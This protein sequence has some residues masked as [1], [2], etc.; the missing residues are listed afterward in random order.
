MSSGS[1]SKGFWFFII[2]IFL[3]FFGF[4]FFLMSQMNSESTLSAVQQ[5]KPHK[6]DQLIGVVDIQGP[7]FESR[8]TIEKLHQASQ[9]NSLS[10]IIVRIDSPGGAVGPVQE[11]YEEILRI[12]KQKPVYASFGTIAASGGYYI[13]AAT[14]KIFANSGTLTG[15]IGVIFQFANLSKLYEW[16]KISLKTVKAGRYKDIGNPSREMTVEE[17]QLLQ[18]TTDQVHG[19]F[20]RD[21]LARRKDKIKGD[22][23]EYAQGQIFSGE[24]A[25]KIGLVDDIAGLWEAGRRI[26]QELKLKGEMELLFIK[27]K[28]PF[29][30]MDFLQTL[31]EASSSLKGFLKLQ[32]TPSFLY[33]PAH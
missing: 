32:N 5:Q 17:L 27:D 14:R 6:K 2:F 4:L 18:S 30:M 20:K 15:S 22:M 23:N 21:I 10:A 31:E 29:K 13:G 7:I 16:A 1:S 9:E 3:L 8:K 11:I 25:L 26:H 19:Q 28:K 33:Q 24:E 12:D